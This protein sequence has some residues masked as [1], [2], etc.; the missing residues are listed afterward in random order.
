[1]IYDE[2]TR[3]VDQVVGV[4]VEQCQYLVA[5]LCLD[6]WHKDVEH[7][8][9][10]FIVHLLI[11]FVLCFFA[12]VGGLDELIMLRGHHDGVHVQGTVV[13][14]VFD[15]DL[16]LGIWTEVGHLLAFL[17]DV[18]QR[19]H[20]EVGQV[21]G[22]RHVVVGFVDGI[23]EH[24]ALVAGSLVVIVF[25]GDTAVDVLALLMDGCQD[26]TAVAVELIVRL[27]IANTVDSLACDGLQVDVLRRAHL[28]HD[29]HLSCGIESLDGAVGVWVVS[30]ELVEQSVADLVSNLV[31]MS[32]RNGF[33]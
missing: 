4:V 23:A 15:G 3:G 17:P 30:Q 12:V 25:T 7:V 33:G 2:L 26:A 20:D 16:T 21:Y 13:V 22:G 28:T 29:D 6:A 32:F 9:L 14:A 5:Q 19:V 8:V 18:G 24:H 10:D 11:G 1:M 27:G 31:G